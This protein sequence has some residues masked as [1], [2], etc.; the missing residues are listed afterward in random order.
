M[1]PVNPLAQF[2][3]RIQTIARFDQSEP[4]QKTEVKRG[5]HYFVPMY[6]EAQSGEPH[7]AERIQAD[8]Q[9]LH[10]HLFSKANRRHVN[11]DS[12]DSTT[13]DHLARRERRVGYVHDQ[14]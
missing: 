7:A 14:S 2:I 3:A 13:G 4:E 1:T 8:V 12:A 9:R 5:S 11:W 10:D 6:R